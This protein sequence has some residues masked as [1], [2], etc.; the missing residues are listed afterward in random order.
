MRKIK[1][2][3]LLLFVLLLAGCNKTPTDK[4]RAYMK[5]HYPDLSVSYL[6]TSSAGYK[7]IIS[8]KTDDTNFT[9]WVSKDTISDNLI[10]TKKTKEIEKIIADSLKYESLVKVTAYSEASFQ[11]NHGLSGLTYDTDISLA[12]YLKLIKASEDGRL[13]AVID[14][15]AF[16]NENFEAIQEEIGKLVLTGEIWEQLSDAD[17]TVTVLVNS[18]L[19]CSVQ[20]ED[21]KLVEGTLVNYLEDTTTIENSKKD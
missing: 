7:T 5:E 8:A 10:F 18:K 9:I 20:V 4:A 12:D 19:V 15:T 2:A 13:V 16:T 14:F 17:F 6:M 3:F 21:G 1:A 11:E